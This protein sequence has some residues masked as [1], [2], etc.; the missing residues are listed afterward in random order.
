MFTV[1]V[2]KKGSCE[3]VHVAAKYVKLDR[4]LHLY[5]PR[6][7]VVYVLPGDVVTEVDLDA[8]NVTCVYIVNGLGKT[9]DRYHNSL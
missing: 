9:V 5:A 6:M 3:E 7:D 4:I 8:E 1:K 2:E